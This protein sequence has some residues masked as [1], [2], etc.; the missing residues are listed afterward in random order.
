MKT[1]FATK[2]GTEIPVDYRMFLRDNRWRAYDVNIEGV[3]LV[4]N[5]RSQFN[6]VIQSR[7]YSALVERL[8]SKEPDAAASPSAPR[9]SRGERD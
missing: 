9:R 3:S 1:K 8:R 4:N 6:T 2:Q 5:Y 7:S